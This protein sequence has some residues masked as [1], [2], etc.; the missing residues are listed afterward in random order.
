MD[1][2]NLK[3]KTVCP[4]NS[5]TKVIKYSSLIPLIRDLE[6]NEESKEKVKSLLILNH[7]DDYDP[8]ESDCT[9]L[10]YALK[11]KK[12]SWIKFLLENSANPAL[13]TI[14]LEDRSE[15]S[16]TDFLWCKEDFESIINLLLADSPF[17]REYE[18][19]KLRF[20]KT[21][22]P[23]Y[24]IRFTAFISRHQALRKSIE[25]DD[26]EAVE[27]FVKSNRKIKHAYDDKNKCA[28]TFAL[29]NK[30]FKIYA[31]LRSKGFAKGVDRKHDEEILLLN[32]KE[33]KTLN[34]E[35]RKY[36][37]TADIKILNLL[38]KSCIG[39]NNEETCFDKIKEF[40]EA[41]NS[42]ED[43]R[44]ILEIAAC[45]NA[46]TITFD[47]NSDDIEDLDLTNCFSN[48]YIVN[49]RT[50]KNG[51]KILIAARRNRTDLLGTLAQE[52][53]HF[54]L[55]SLY[56]NGFL[57]YSENDEKRKLMYG[58]VVEVCRLIRGDEE[59][60]ESAFLYEEED[61]EAELI[62]RV[63]QLLVV[64]KEDQGKLEKIS[65]RFN[66]L[67]DFF[68]L[69]ILPDILKEI[70]LVKQKKKIKELNNMFGVF[71]F[72]IFDSIK[73]TKVYC[74]KLKPELC[75]TFKDNTNIFVASKTPELAFS[76]V[77]QALTLNNTDNIFVKMEQLMKNN[78]YFMDI[79]DSNIPIKLFII[80]SID[81]DIIDG[82]KL[83][84]EIMNEFDVVFI[85]SRKFVASMERCHEYHL[86]FKWDDLIK[87]SQNKILDYKVSFQGLQ[88]KFKNLLDE[89][90]D[91]VTI[92][93][94]N[95]LLEIYKSEINNLEMLRR[96]ARK[97]IARS[98]TEPLKEETFGE[99]GVLAKLNLEKTV[100]LADIAGMG[101]TTSAV[102]FVEMITLSNQLFWIVFLDLKQHIKYFS[103]NQKKKLSKLEFL[104][105]LENILNFK[106]ETEK[107]LFNFF[108]E[109]KKSI[110]IVDGFDEIS[111]LFKEFV[112]KL[113][114]HVQSSENRLLVTTRMHLKKLLEEN[115][116]LQAINLLPF[117]EKDQI[118][119]IVENLQQ[120]SRNQASELLP[121][122][123][124]DEIRSKIKSLQEKM[125]NK[126][127]T[128]LEQ[129]MLRQMKL[130]KEANKILK[131]FNTTSNKK[132]IFLKIP[133]QLFMF[134]KIFG[135]QNFTKRD[136]NI[137]SL[138]MH[139][140]DSKMNIW[141][142]KGKLAADENKEIH[143]SKF[144]ISQIHQSLAIKMFYGETICDSM[145]IRKP[146]DPINE[147]LICRIGLM[148]LSLNGELQFNHETFAD[149]FVAQFLIESLIMQEYEKMFEVSHGLLVEVIVENNY[150]YENIRKFINA[151]FIEKDKFFHIDLISERLELLLAVQSN[152][153]FLIKLI[154]AKHFHL[155]NFVLVKLRLSLE[156][157]LDIIKHED[158]SGCNSLNIAACDVESWKNLWECI[159]SFTEKSTRKELLLIEG[160]PD[161]KNILD[162]S[163]AQKR[164][165]YDVILKTYRELWKSKTRTKGF[166]VL[167][168]KKSQKKSQKKQLK[169]NFS[170]FEIL[171][172]SIEQN[173]DVQFQKDLLFT[174]N[175]DNTL[176]YDLLDN[177]ESLKIALKTIK[178]L[179]NPNELNIFL[180][181]EDLVV[182]IE[183]QYV[184]KPQ[185]VKKF[186]KFLRKTLKNIAEDSI[187]TKFLK[188]DVIGGSLEGS[189]DK[190]IF[191]RTI[192]CFDRIIKIQNTNFNG[193]HQNVAWLLQ[194]VVQL[195]I[196]S[197]EEF[198]SIMWEFI[199]QRVTAEEQKTLMLLK[200]ES[201]NTLTGV[202]QNKNKQLMYYVYDKLI[203]LLKEKDLQDSIQSS[204][205]NWVVETFVRYARAADSK[206][207]Q[208]FW[209]LFKEKEKAFKKT[210][211]LQKQHKGANALSSSS[212]NKNLST[213]KL[214]LAIA[215][216]ILEPEDF[217]AAARSPRNRWV[218][219][220]IWEYGGNAG[221]DAFQVFW[222]F[223]N[224]NKTQDDLKSML[225]ACARNKCRETVEYVIN[226]VSGSIPPE[227]YSLFPEFESQS[228]V[229][230]A[231]CSFAGKANIEN[232]EIFW[233]FIETKFC[234]DDQKLILISMKRNEHNMLISC[235]QNEDNSTIKYIFEKATHL[236]SS[237]DFTDT[238]Q[239]WIL[240]TL[241]Y[242]AGS[243][244]LEAFQFFWSFLL[245]KIDLNRIS[246]LNTSKKNMVLLSCW[247]NRDKR[248][249][250]F[251]FNKAKDL[252]T[253]TLIIE[254]LNN[255]ALHAECETFAAIWQF[256]KKLEQFDL[257]SIF[258]KI[259]KGRSVFRS[260]IKN[261]D[262]NTI[263]LIFDIA[264]EFLTEDSL[265]SDYVSDPQSWV[266]ETCSRYCA[267]SK[268]SVFEIF[269]SFIEKTFDADEQKKLLWETQTGLNSLIIMAKNKN[270]D[271]VRKLFEILR[272]IIT[273]DDA[274]EAMQNTNINFWVN[275][276][277]RFALRAKIENFEVFWSFVEEYLD[278]EDQKVILVQK[279]SNG[280]NALMC[281][282]KNK[283]LGTVKKV[284]EIAKS[285]ITEKDITEGT[286]SGDG[287]WVV[288]SLIKFSA[289]AKLEAFNLFWSILKE[290]TLEE[291]Q[292][293]IFVQR[294]KINGYNVIGSSARNKDQRTSKKVLNIAK[295]LF[296]FSSKDFILDIEKGTDS[297]IVD[298]LNMYA[299]YAGK[300]VFV[301]FWDIVF[302][303]LKDE[304][305]IKSIFMQKDRKGKNVM[306]SSAEND[307]VS[308]LEFIFEKAQSLLLPDKVYYNIE[309]L[310][311]DLIVALCIQYASFADIEGFKTFWNFLKKTVANE[312]LKSAFLTKDNN[313]YNALMSSAENE[314]KSTTK[315]VLE[316]AEELLSID[317][318]R[319]YTFFVYW[320]NHHH[321]DFMKFEIKFTVEEINSYVLKEFFEYNLVFAITFIGDEAINQNLWNKLLQLLEPHEI[322][323]K[324][325]SKDK[326]E[327][328]A[329]HNALL[330]NRQI[331]LSF[332]EW[333]K[334]NCNSDVRMLFEERT[335]KSETLMHLLASDCDE[336]LWKEV[337]NFVKPLLTEAE[338]DV[339]LVLEDETGQTP[340]QLGDKNS[341]SKISFNEFLSEL[342]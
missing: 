192:S 144:N 236:L 319:D 313:G 38:S 39:I 318:Y 299:I 10:C 60:I 64:Y 324:L 234:E 177:Q 8:N 218:F 100:L 244:R 123:E 82:E 128:E 132:Q 93:P 305:A 310:N 179:F 282:A 87:K 48:D 54:A 46:L 241:K 126:T 293:T 242:Y 7:V 263:K 288:N 41:L 312:F 65:N 296:V 106:T 57:P 208:I 164:K 61:L 264:S 311:H 217:L 40:Y 309:L 160:G 81:I 88:Y 101:K 118:I 15:Q 333:F 303:I 196:Y 3:R 201:H 16:I 314:N 110:F 251:I 307:D 130:E 233:A 56:N 170:A 323:T 171:W 260:C 287:S 5:V 33:K 254:T 245:L 117:T 95:E 225:K 228:W 104:K 274:S 220:T 247:N 42:I 116:K 257:K 89:N 261:K 52:L 68:K 231:A 45:E 66:A 168:H 240:K 308:T 268:L 182:N 198:Y 203:P 232:F 340:L 120:E 71:N 256:F 183:T 176:F 181:T 75:A 138:Y 306:L 259:Y 195:S 237:H 342:R 148:Q 213:I 173:F 291:V 143:N 85:S 277:C 321:K 135:I 294:K 211:L 275:I 167:E 32:P 332:F 109:N 205:H 25:D 216:E 157:K 284:L 44:P 92:L 114:L 4:G 180:R 133:L 131:K 122:T 175:G 230:K 300:E 51:K 252:F 161:K 266:L 258:L 139:F 330:N 262:K 11:C 178:K 322:K 34:N 18:E 246:S 154:E 137:S 185:V 184:S 129:V 17:P 59:I 224:R 214:I 149:F 121:L 248:T 243:A 253:R 152:R 320:F 73:T 283:D 166:S 55:M 79:R 124:L 43:L 159:Q 86:N 115:L 286:D 113:I 145:Q 163:K 278:D 150:Y 83:L 189:S 103:A 197:N 215:E 47:F 29:E 112:L 190:F 289:H 337:F 302:D 31:L 155:L 98:Y 267:F 316:I 37:K 84:N 62:S 290:R 99:D 74:E 165:I 156:T 12:H 13:A 63:P 30:K 147:E 28:L 279:K 219:R 235:F 223:F 6:C 136:L 2:N 97:Y 107:S 23:I 272:T 134:S 94:L 194:I 255:F 210:I 27:D 80:D 328:N 199:E 212:E 169:D 271:T 339:L 281:S 125:K 19:H 142:E 200:H 297:W 221:I 338:I 108:W 69:H 326:D 21:L 285:L 227:D 317:D 174:N 50:F 77:V 269:W 53:T 334:N 91:K 162:W 111:P 58:Q 1:A 187:V 207:F 315:L 295:R 105:T 193:P 141:M 270:T 273:T 14:T 335:N 146:K 102:K 276:F 67:F 206:A 325:L 327:Y 153:I 301:K 298:S 158:L 238:N 90:I 140:I 304:I 70:K 96:E 204:K 191:K 22:K 49:G 202:I 72:F 20:R 229:I 24:L 222:S 151:M 280:L 331:V 249:I 172:Q 329:F 35:I 226:I 292:R 239:S 76:T 127:I 26:I 336:N 78:S 265:S 188:I 9:P 250:L 119:F 36:F 209:S 341:R 186:Q